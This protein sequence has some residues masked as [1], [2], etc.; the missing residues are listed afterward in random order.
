MRIYYKWNIRNIR[1]EYTQGWDF[2]TFAYF[3]LDAQ[4]IAE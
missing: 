2:I 4:E 3:L 1:N